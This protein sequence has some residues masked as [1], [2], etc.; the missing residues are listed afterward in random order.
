MLPFLF[1][2]KIDRPTQI[3][4]TALEL[5]SKL[6]VLKAYE[7]LRNAD[8]DKVLQAFDTAS[9][10]T[11]LECLMVIALFVLNLRRSFCSLPPSSAYFQASTNPVKKMM[12]ESET[13]ENNK[14]CHVQK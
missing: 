9:L 2:R 1:S 10:K 5:D 13:P 4:Q 7:I 8:I 12:F 6:S 11:I 3:S 14:H